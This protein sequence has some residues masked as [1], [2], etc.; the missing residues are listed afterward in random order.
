MQTPKEPNRLNILQSARKEFLKAGYEKASMRR[1]A[2]LASVSPSNIYNYFVS[3]EEILE[4]ILR[5][6]LDGVEKGVSLISDDDYM[7]RRLQ[8]SYETLKM[9]FNVALD[10]VDEHRELFKLLICHTTSSKYERFLEELTDQVTKINMRQLDYFK[11]THKI[12]LETH[13]FF[14]RNLV[15]FFVNVF[16]EMIRNDIPKMEIVKIEDQL[17]KFLHFGSKAILLDSKT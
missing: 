1:I 8:F 10:F 15:S 11:R 13:E 12:E 14:V 6:A 9:R 3:K 16:V 4:T 2:K 5:P 17:L 7:E